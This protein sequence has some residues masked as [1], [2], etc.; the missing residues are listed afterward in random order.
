MRKQIL[1]YN[2]FSYFLQYTLFNTSSWKIKDKKNCLAYKWTL[3]LIMK[4]VT[5]ERLML[6]CNGKQSY[7]N[8]FIFLE[9]ILTS[10]T[11]ILNSIL[12]TYSLKIKN[13]V[14]YGFV[15]VRKFFAFRSRSNCETP[16]PRSEKVNRSPE[17]CRVQNVSPVPITAENILVLSQSYLNKPHIVPE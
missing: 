10:R 3:L 8:V 15:L 2:C 13:I 14:W 11:T 9:C 7:P 4:I 1:Q 16:D 12:Y 17:R 6:N 5:K